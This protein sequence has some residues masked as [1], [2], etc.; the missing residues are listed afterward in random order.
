MNVAFS[1][2][3]LAA[4][5]AGAQEFKM[6]YEWLKEYLDEHSIEVLGLN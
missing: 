1:P 4:Y 2:Y 5:A 6:P 3:E